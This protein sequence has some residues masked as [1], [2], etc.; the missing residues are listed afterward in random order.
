[1]TKTSS[2]IQDTIVKVSIDL[3][4]IKEVDDLKKD[5]IPYGMIMK[6]PIIFVICVWIVYWVNCN[7]IC[8]V[9][10]KTKTKGVEERIDRVCGQNK[11][12]T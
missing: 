10:R 6:S 11:G 7:G 5:K 9:G 12:L 4:H 8:A 1:M 3:R 2:N